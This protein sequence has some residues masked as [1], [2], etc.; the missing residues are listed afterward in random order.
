MTTFAPALT[1]RDRLVLLAAE[2]AELLAA[3][4]ASV[5]AEQL[6][7]ADPLIHLRHVLASRGQLPPAGARP[8]QLLARPAITAVPAVGLPSVRGVA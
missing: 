5:A 7:E 6:G 2:H 8:V 3:A 4:R 1:D